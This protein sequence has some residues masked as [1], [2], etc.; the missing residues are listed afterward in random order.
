MLL[1]TL[2]AAALRL[3]HLDRL[4]PGLWYDEAVN[5]VDIRMV[6]AGRGLPIYFVANNGR[7]PLFIY[8]Q[9]LSVALL[10]PTP[11]A[12]RLVSAIAGIL[13]VPA[14]YWCG[15]V[16]FGGAPHDARRSRGDL[17]QHW[18]PLI[19][20]AA[21]A[22]SYWHLSLS[23]LGLRAVLLP[24]TSTLAVGFFWKAWTGGRRRDYALAGV[25]LAAALYSYLAARLLPFVLLAFVALEAVL[26]LV[27]RARHASG[28]AGPAVEIH[29]RRAGRPR[30]RGRGPVPAA[31]PGAPQRGNH[32]RSL[33]PGFDPGRR[34]ARRG[35]APRRREC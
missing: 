10:G 9:A 31:G 20:A 23:R 3:W 25:F 35:P 26:A 1:V 8:L 27:A 29:P 6:L 24:L 17:I 13:A 21:L 32:D 5:G 2:A 16:L 30:A 18:A 28:R 14:V 33:E 15:R 11:F 7:E 34:P 12:L 19:A 22:V 4:P